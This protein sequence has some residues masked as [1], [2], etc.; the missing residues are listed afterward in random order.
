VIGLVLAVVVCLAVGVAIGVW[1]TLVFVRRREAEAD[2]DLAR[3]PGPV[4]TSR[5]PASRMQWPYLPV[6]TA[7]CPGCLSSRV[8][9][10]SFCHRC[11]RLT[12]RPPAMAAPRSAGAANPAPVVTVLP[13]G[14]E[15]GE[16]EPARLSTAGER[17]LD[18]V[19]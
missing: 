15:G 12:S 16:T 5:S 11:G 4:V 2:R 8:R 10:A 14:P 18:A 19:S 13:P 1:L 7:D 9:G 6:A 17:E 3:G